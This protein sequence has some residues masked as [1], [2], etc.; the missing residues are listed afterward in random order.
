MPIPDGMQGVTISGIGIGPDGSPTAGRLKIRPRPLRIVSTTTGHIVQ[1]SR[2]VSFDANG[3]YSITVI[4]TDSDL[5]DPQGF[6]YHIELEFNDASGYEFDAQ[7]PKAAPSVLLSAIVPV[8]PTNGNYQ[9]VTGPAGQSA[10]DLAVDDGFEGTEEEWLASLV[11][12]GAS[13]EWVFNIED[14]GAVGDAQVAIE[15]SITASDATLTVA[16]AH[17]TN[18]MVGNAIGI[19]GAAA[20][21]V[22]WHSTTIA[23]VTNSTT[24]ELTNAAVSSISGALVVWGTDNQVFI[25]DA[26]DAAEEYLTAHTFARVYI[27]PRAYI[28]AG[29]LNTSKSGNGHIVFGVYDVG[30]VKRILEFGGESSGAAAVR[31]WLQTVPQFAGS[32]IIS[33]GVYASTSAQIADLNAHGNSGILCGP[34]EASGYGIAANY[35]NVM[36]V[37]KNLALLNAHSSLG[38]TYG[39][40]WLFGC[41]NSYIEN[42]GVGTLGTVAEPST[43][44][45]S[46]GTFGT[47]LSI[48][49]G[50]PADG[51]NDHNIVNNLSIGGGYTYGLFLTEHGLV[52]R[53]MVLYC[54]AAICAVGNYAGSVGATHAMKV[55]QASV[56][57]CSR[58]VYI[59]GVASEGIGPIIDIDQLQT[60]SSHPTIDGNSEGALAGAL[61]RIK[62]TGLF[63]SANVT[64]VMPTGIEVVNGQVAR[65][66]SIKTG[67]YSA[68]ILDRTLIFDTSSGNLTL[69]LTNADYN[70]AQ[71]TVSNVGSNTLTIDSVSG[72]S[73]FTLAQDETV[74]LQAVF[75]G[76]AWSWYKT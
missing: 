21:G 49:V 66:I 39:A 42:V 2:E 72:D 73:L 41:A 53:I 46:P 31:I 30:K 70:P 60:E 55:I 43:D 14:Y 25:Q 38:L 13:Q 23:S 7:L 67:N 50:L 27:P 68:T 58:E 8:D 37:V 11:G 57:S 17:F 61:G 9:I 65:S 76:I 33:F 18:A 22:T 29:A 5:I 15:G 35:S 56:E 69:T 51:N 59:I 52:P 20:S 6:S 32:C 4:A 40:V 16:D 47:G 45:S 3:D 74:R 28:V 26:V 36:V 48:A 62:L 44:Y 64:S 63:N 54:F 12:A 19:K 34:N 10:Y 24:V 75:N 71:F 1:G